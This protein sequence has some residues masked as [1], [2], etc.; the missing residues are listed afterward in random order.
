MEDQLKEAKHLYQQSLL[1]TLFD[2]LLVIKANEELQLLLKDHATSFNTETLPWIEKMLERIVSLQEVSQKFH[3]QLQQLFKQP[4]LVLENPTLQNR[5]I[6][7]SKYFTD[8]LQKELQLLQQ[9]PA[10]TDSRLMAKE[11]NEKLHE[12]YALLAE[13]KFLFSIC[14]NG[15]DATSWHRKKKEF[16]L[17]AFTVNAY[18]GSSTYTNTESPHPVLHQQL[19]KLRDDICAKNH[20]PIYIVAGTVTLYEMSRYLPQRL[21]ELALVSGFGKVKLE[22]Y[23]NQFLNVIKQY[24][25]IHKLSSLIH[26]KNS[27]RQRKEKNEAQTDT[28]SETYKLYK[29]GKSVNK[30]AEIRNFT[31]QTIEGHLAHYV[32]KGE[33]TIDELVSREKLVLIEPAIK[34]FKGGSITPV[35]QQLGDDVSFGEIR[36]VMAWM[37]FQKDREGK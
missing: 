12:I 29:E 8:Q 14:M 15:F 1:L 5:I 35:K 11:Y 21:E 32:Q 34:D 7:A 9:S 23:G 17:P 28:K 13:K 4:F 37:D 10:V 33:I 6:A 19:R 26:E 22:S 18:A 31:R 24:C 16:V 30:I 27:R 20:Q 36:L 3:P 25:G 2:F